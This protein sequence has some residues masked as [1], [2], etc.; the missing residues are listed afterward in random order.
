MIKLLSLY[1][2]KLKLSGSILLKG[3]P[4]FK[5]KHWTFTPCWAAVVFPTKLLN[6]D[7]KII[8]KRVQQ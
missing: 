3:Y 8:P 2:T 4:Y 1:G 5:D 7:Y 6:K